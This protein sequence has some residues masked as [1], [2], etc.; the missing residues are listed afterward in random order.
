MT[1]EDYAEFSSITKQYNPDFDSPEPYVI[2][3]ED[4]ESTKQHYDKNTLYYYEQDDT[5]TDDAE[6]I[7]VDTDS[8]IGDMALTLFGELSDDPDAVYIRNDKK[9]SDFEV[10]R[11]NKS[12]SVSVL[13]LVEER[14]KKGRIHDE[15]Q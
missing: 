13:G 10:L 8:L 1:E 14:N 7:L 5:V 9:S 4:F 6:E 11:L 12:Y 3:F 15:E 2:S